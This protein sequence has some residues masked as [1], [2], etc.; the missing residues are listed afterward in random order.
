MEIKDNFYYGILFEY[1]KELLT[2]KQKEY[3]TMYY[4]ENFSLIEIA[5][6]YDVSKESVFDLIK[7]V[8]KKL[9]DYE[10]KLCLYKKSLEIEKLL[11]KLKLSD[12]II[13]QITEMI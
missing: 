12:D 8:N 11:K 1:Y 4:E 2:E 3:L 7:R 5:N 13:D 9:N 10:Q 6:E